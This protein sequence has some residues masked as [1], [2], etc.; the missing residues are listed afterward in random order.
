MI[1]INEVALRRVRLVLGW[2]TVFVSIESQDI[3]TC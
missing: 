2:V 1:A 3:T